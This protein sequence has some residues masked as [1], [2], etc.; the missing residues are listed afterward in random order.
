[1]PLWES[2]GE[3]VGVDRSNSG[4][5]DRS[6]A[7]AAVPPSDAVTGGVAGGS[8]SL[9]KVSSG[10]AVQGGSTVGSTAGGT[11]AVLSHGR[12]I[13]RA[14]REEILA[15][16]LGSKKGAGLLS[17]PQAAAAAPHP[18]SSCPLPDVS[19][20][21]AAR[22]DGTRSGLQGIEGVGPGLGS[23]T[24]TG[25]PLSQEQSR[26]EEDEEERVYFGARL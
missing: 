16:L 12:V 19:A 21:S 23:V 4:V 3:G 8:C 9:K 14:E 5:V 20:L 2:V 6:A 15:G 13:S 10:A 26:R 25:V 17:L 7:T 11:K 1:M 22:N 18:P 24:V